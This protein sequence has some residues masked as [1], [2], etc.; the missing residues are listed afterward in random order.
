MNPVICQFRVKRFAPMSWSGFTGLMRIFLIN[1]WS[2]C[3]YL[4]LLISI[5]AEDLASGSQKEELANL[6]LTP[7][8]EFKELLKPASLDSVSSGF[9]VKS[10][11]E[12]GV[13]FTN[14]LG[15]APGAAN[16]TLW[17]GSGVAV[18]DVNGDG[19]PDLFFCGLQTP[20]QLY[21]NSGDWSFREATQDAGLV[22]PEGFYRGAVFADLDGD[23]DLDLIVTGVA[24]GARV[25]LN[26]G[27]GSFTDFSQTAGMA[28]P[29]GSMTVALADVDRDGDLDVYLTNNRSN[30]IRDEGSIPLTMRNGQVTVPSRLQNRLIFK[31]G[32][33][34]EYGEP[35]LLF[36]NDGQARFKPMAWHTEDFL[37]SKGQPLARPPLDWGLS[38]AF[39]DINQDGWPDIYVCNDYWT[40]DRVWLNLGNGKFQEAGPM[41]FRHQPASS[42][43]VDFSDIDRD[44][45]VDIFAVD[46]LSRDPRLRIQQMPAQDHADWNTGKWEEV[47]QYGRNMLY[48]NRG[49]G[50]FAEIANLA[51]LAASDWSWTPMFMD[52]DLD[53]YEDLLI[54]AGHFKNVQ[55]RDAAREVMRRQKEFPKGA[56][57]LRKK[58]LFAESMQENNRLYPDLKLPIVAFRNQRNLT[59]T[60]TTVEWGLEA[61]LGV[62]HGMARADLD[63]DGD[64]DLI[65]NRLGQPAG[66]IENLASSPRLAI[67]LKGS[68]RNTGAV[69]ARLELARGATKLQ[70]EEIDLGGRYLSGSDSLVVFGTGGASN[71]TELKVIWPDGKLGQYTGLVAGRLYF[72]DY[73]DTTFTDKK[74]IVLQNESSEASL[75]WLERIPF[76][77]PEVERELEFDDFQRQPTLPWRLSDSGARLAWHDSDDDG[78]EELWVGAGRGAPVSAYEPMEV[79]GGDIEWKLNQKLAT[80]PGFLQN[81]FASF[82]RGPFSNHE[83]A[84]QSVLLA[85][86]R[87]Y[88]SPTAK[89]ESLV[90]IEHAGEGLKAGELDLPSRE[91]G[92][93]VGNLA[94]ADYDA[95]GDLDLWVGGGDIAGSFPMTSSH[96]LY[97]RTEDG[98]EL[99]KPNTETVQKARFISRALW[100]DLTGDGYPELVLVP[101]IGAIYVFQNQEGILKEVTE[102]W[103]FDNYQGAWTALSA[104]DW[105]GDGRMDLALGTYGANQPW[106]LPEDQEVTWFYRVNGER[107]DWIETRNDPSD[108]TLVYSREF[109]TIAQVAPA[110]YRK[111]KSYREFS[112]AKVEED[113]QSIWPDAVEVRLNHFESGIFWNTGSKMIWESFPIEAQLAPVW[114]IAAVDLDMDGQLEAVLAQNSSGLRTEFARMDAGRGLILSR[115]E[116]GKVWDVISPDRTGLKLLQETRS[117]AVG[118]WNQD[119]RPDLA[120]SLHGGSPEL[121]Q[122]KTISRGIQITLRGPRGNPDGIG[123]IIRLRTPGGMGAAFENYGGK[124]SGSLNSGKILLGV[125][126]LPQFIWVRWPGGRVSLSR[127]EE[128]ESRQYEVL[129][130]DKT[131]L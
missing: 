85:G 71:P 40:P 93:P 117:I 57:P 39:Q 105:N 14:H 27:A 103:G 122:N 54:S 92:Q 2:L 115:N 28:G 29:F 69:G 73:D 131:N 78:I 31:D 52:V 66:L 67:R 129:W 41:Q 55:D 99:D 65:V 86:L 12:T 25:Y 126:D 107:V 26:D 108:G 102:S 4:I 18:G 37:D 72:I 88:E 110:V 119:L 97:R 59:F 23:L 80:Y 70:T 49:D 7:G 109:E 77:A 100:S 62:N 1:L 95:D 35:D 34:Q 91:A 127:V 90:F 96:A 68:R 113:I 89:S 45:W 5:P 63:G 30:D 130:P 75:P 104:G 121:F 98:W 21:L 56:S 11:E 15:E 10:P 47:Q 125:T 74:G 24:L 17:N 38:A 112:E 81:D 43:G 118:D 60:E 101:H 6:K 83:D 48:W 8:V 53:G 50:S 106:K 33:I 44:G 16:R 19:L 9:R 94:V 76:Q 32:K 36:L 58:Q 13:Q 64:L 84:N 111:Y 3:G 114:D 116:T 123:A 51:G 61:M 82:V 87:K 128:N 120:I 42:M 79:A 46:M 22:F 124:S 20:N